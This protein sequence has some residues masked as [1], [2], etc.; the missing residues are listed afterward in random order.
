MNLDDRLAT[1]AD[2]VPPGA[3]VADVGT[4]HAYLAVELQRRG[5]ALV[6]ASDKNAGPCYAAKET[7]AAAGLTGKIPVRQGDGL[8]VL[9]PGEVDTVCLAGMGGKLMAEILAAAPE[10]TAGCRALV[11]QPM[12]DAAALRRWLHAHG[13]A[14]KAE[15]LA[16]AAGQLYV[17]LRAEPGTEVYADE[18]HYLVGPRLVEERPPLFRA[19]VQAIITKASL[20]AEGMA[21][22]EAARQSA[23]YAALREEI[24]RLQEVLSC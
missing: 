24:K 19:H 6:I 14:I 13:W 12:N 7:I 23:R 3:K 2:L 20:A 16:E 4:D 18:L 21:K 9:T 17:V 22:S 1:V 8:A 5:A 10:V 15:V 11:L